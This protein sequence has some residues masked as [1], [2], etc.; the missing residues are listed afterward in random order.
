MTTT[1]ENSSTPALTRRYPKVIV[2]C[3]DA[4]GAPAFHSCSPECT[5][6]D[7][8]NGV[9]YDK[10]IE[11]AEFNGYEQPMIAFDSTD[12]AARQLAD[13]QGWLAEA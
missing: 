3:T 13:L 10:A 12:P 1:D 6:E 8:K 9:H 11:N 4:N 2:L 7:I 5:E